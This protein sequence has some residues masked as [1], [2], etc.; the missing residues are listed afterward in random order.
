ML[1]PPGLA[2]I[3]GSSCNALWRVGHC[4]EIPQLQP[5]KCLQQ[6]ILR[7][8]RYTFAQQHYIYIYVQLYHRTYVFVVLW[9]WVC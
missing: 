4:S 3:R 5:S 8:G 1:R 2:D 9:L 6:D 7:C